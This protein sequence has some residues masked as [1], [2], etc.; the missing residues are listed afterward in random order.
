MG[1]ADHRPASLLSY[2]SALLNRDIGVGFWNKADALAQAR[3]EEARTGQPHAIRMQAT[4]HET[5]ELWFVN[6]VREQV[7]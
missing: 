1:N 6:E 2:Q 3:A 4:A 5:H 7:A